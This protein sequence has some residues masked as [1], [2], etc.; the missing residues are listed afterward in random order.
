MSGWHLEYNTDAD[1]ETRIVYE[2][3]FGVWKVET[4]RAYKDD[5]E[6][7]VAGLIDEPWIKFTDLS[8]WK[9]GYPEIIDIIGSHMKWAYEHNMQWMIHVINNVTT[10]KQL[11]QM[12]EK[13]GAKSVSQIF[14]TRPEAEAFIKKQ[15]Y[16]L[17]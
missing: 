6:E 13:S 15:G 5:F 7:E 16:K 3:I 10:Y 11:V 12:I 8:N 9:I 17:R 2:K 1:P 14:R 4:A